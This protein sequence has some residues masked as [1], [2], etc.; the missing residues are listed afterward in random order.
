MFAGIRARNLLSVENILT[1][2]Q[3]GLI[4]VFAVAVRY[5]IQKP[6]MILAQVGRVFGMC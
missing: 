5:L 4:I 2:K 6:S 1:A 3:Q